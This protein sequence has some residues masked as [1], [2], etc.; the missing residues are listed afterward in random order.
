MSGQVRAVQ[1]GVRT[2]CRMDNYIRLGVILL[3]VAV[4][5]LSSPGGPPY[6]SWA[7]FGLALVALLVVALGFLRL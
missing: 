2:C 4:I 5:V 6:K 7:S 3:A 1:R